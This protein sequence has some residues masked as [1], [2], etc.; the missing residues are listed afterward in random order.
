MFSCKFCE[1]SKN[2]FF[3]QHLWSLLLYTFLKLSVGNGLRSTIFNSFMTS[4]FMVGTSIMKNSYAVKYLWNSKLFTKK[5][6]GKMRLLSVECNSTFQN[7]YTVK[8]MWNSKLFTKRCCEKKLSERTYRTDWDSTSVKNYL[9]SYSFLSIF[10]ASSSANVSIKHTPTLLKIWNSW[11][12][13]VELASTIA[14]K[15]GS[16]VPFRMIYQQ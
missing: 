2:T 9:Q 15:K 13:W 6:C 7:S 10:Q 11:I 3:M 16:V 4:F 12:I 14:W 1:L 5:C 8:H